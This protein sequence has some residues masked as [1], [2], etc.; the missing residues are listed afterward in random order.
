MITILHG[1]DLVASRSH[2]LACLEKSRLGG[3]EIIWL[4]KG[5]LTGERTSQVFGESTLFGGSTTVVL[6]NYLK[7]KPT[8]N[9]LLERSSA[10]IFL[11]EDDKRAPTSLSLFP[12]AK[13]LEFKLPS[14]LFKFLDGLRPNS[15]KSNIA[16]YRLALVGS[17]AEMIFALL[18]RRFVDLLLPPAKA[19]DWQRA[20]L[21]GQSRMFP[22]GKLAKSIHD[23]VALD[24]GQK[25]SST[26]LS[27]TDELE[28]FLCRL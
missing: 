27:L 10:E 13:V 4:G 7:L 14:S 25:T 16:L 28:L 15:P 3:R 2:L 8:L 23:L 18:A 9:K 24:L 21:L 26:P 1:Q 20:R 6:E 11:W 19:A 17:S 5:D 22:Q 12:G